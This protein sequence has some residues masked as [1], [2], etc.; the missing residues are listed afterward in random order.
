MQS[1]FP[2]LL[3]AGLL[4]GC[5]LVAALPLVMLAFYNHPSP[6]DDY[7]F[8]DT[9]IKFGYWQ[10]QKFYYEGWSGRYFQN[11]IVHA[12]PLVWNWRE[13]YHIQPLLVL[14]LLWVSFFYLI[15]QLTRSFTTTAVQAVLASGA[16][17]LFLTNLVTVAEFFYWNSGMATYGLS[18]ALILLLIGTFVAHDRRRFDFSGYLVAEFLLVAAIIGSSE[19]SMLMVLSLLGM[20]GLCFLIYRRRIPASYLILLGLSAACCYFMIKAPGNAVRL[21]GNS[22]SQNVV[23]SFIETV[24]YSLRYFP[25]LV[26]RT[27]ILPLSL[28]FLPV[29][30]RLT[31]SRSPLRGAFAVHPL[32]ALLHAGATVFVLTFLHFWAVGIPPVTRLMNVVNMVFLLGW[33]YNLTILV[34]VFRQRVGELSFLTSPSLPLVLAAGLL[35]VLT[36]Y[37]NPMLRM[38]Y[39]DLR[40]GYAK[41]YDLAMK[42]RYALMATGAADTVA[43]APLPVVPASLVTEDIRDNPEHLWNRC[44]ASYYHKKGVRLQASQPV[45]G[46]AHLQTTQQP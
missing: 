9:A 7:C 1:T 36:L 6:A 17:G 29:A 32:L 45:D 18:C 24:K 2:R 3:T 11:M 16:M 28:L 37:L 10:A 21:A 40:Y 34:R 44:W 25:N 35:T 27:P 42:Q 26:L 41:Q 30:Y 15:R 46:T 8:A 31:E 39:G 5:L 12:N 33:F 43:L 38:T 4:L 20:L 19:T 23:F 22:Q 13:G 14:L